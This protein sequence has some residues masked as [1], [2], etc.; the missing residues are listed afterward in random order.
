MLAN[1]AKHYQTGEAMPQELVD[2]IRKAA[3][4][5]KGFDGLE[6]LEAQMLD[7]DW[8]NMTVAQAQAVTDPVAFEKA[9]LEKRGVAFGPIQPRYRTTYFG[10][11]WPGGYAAGYYAYLWTEVLA[12][13]S[14]AYMGTQGGLTR[15]N[16]DK[17]REAILSKGGT[18]EPMDLFKAYR[19]QEP[20]VEGLLMRRGLI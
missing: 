3:T 9:S 7:Q 11:V 10:H 14:F 20:T 12:A 8:H 5:N 13:D 1:Y 6:A 16:G 18:A 17:F 4:F 2:K 15:E 19:G